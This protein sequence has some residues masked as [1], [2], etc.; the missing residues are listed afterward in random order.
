MPAC[1][2]TIYII[3]QYKCTWYLWGSYL[4]T[5]KKKKIRGESLHNKKRSDYHVCG[6]PCTIKKDPTI[7]CVL[8][9]GW[10]TYEKFSATI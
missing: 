1:K 3:E 7:M 6:I 9:R 4:H 2:N 8:G 10:L 5:F